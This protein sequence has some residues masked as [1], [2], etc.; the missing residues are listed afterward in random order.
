MGHSTVQGAQNLSDNWDK[1]TPQQRAKAL[2]ETGVGAALTALT[3]SHA[4]GE[5]E[6]TN[7]AAKLAEPGKKAD[8]AQD[9]VELPVTSA[10]KS[11]GVSATVSA[12]Q[13]PESTFSAPD[14]G[15]LPGPGAK[16]AGTDEVGLSPLQQLR[17]WLPN[18]RSPRQTVVDRM[19]SA[20][21]AVQQRVGYVYDNLQRKAFNAESALMGLW[22]AYRQPPEWTGLDDAIGKWQ[23]ARQY[24][25]HELNQFAETLKASIPDQSRREALTNYLQAGGDENV[26]R[27]RAAASKAQFRRGYRTALTLSPNERVLANNLRNYLDGMLDEAKRGGLLEQGVQDY[28]SQIWQKSPEQAARLQALNAASDLSTNPFFTK[29]RIFKDYFE[30]ESKGFQPVSKDVGFLLSAYEKSFAKAIADKG[31][32]RQLLNTKASDGRPLVQV[33]GVGRTLT[34]GELS[35]ETKAHVI[36]PHAK[37]ENAADYIAIDAPAMRKWKWVAKDDSGNPIYLEGDV[38]AH[39]EVARKLKNVLTPSAI[40]T[41]KVGRAALKLSGEFKNTLLSMSAFH[42]VQ[43]GVHGVEHLVNPTRLPKLALETPTQRALIEHGL[44]IASFDAREAFSEGLHSSGLVNKVP[45]IGKHLARYQDYLFKDYLPRLKMAMASHA[46]ERNTKRYANKLSRD[47][48]LRLTAE[49]ANAAFGHL[50]YAQLG[51]NKTFQDVLRLTLLAP[52]FLEAR[53]R[54]VGQA[55]KPFGREQSRALATGAAVMYVGARVLNQVLNG[56]SYANDPTMAFSVRIRNRVY[57]LRTVQG[58]ILHL[59]EKPREFVE[60]RLNPIATRPLLEAITGRDTF[61]R[62][63]NAKDQLKDFA[64]NIVPIPLQ[65]F[66]KPSDFDVKESV[67]KSLGL[68]ATRYRSPAA[69]TAHELMLKGA[70]FGES[71]RTPAEQKLMASHRAAIDADKFDAGKVRDDFKAGK[72]TEKDARALISESK[73]PQLGRDF[74]RLSLEKALE[75]W[76]VADDEERK[77]LRPILEAKARRQLE[78]RVPSERAALKSKVQAAL[79]EKHAPLKPLPLMLKKILSST[80]GG[81][82]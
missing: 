23:A 31:F 75:V 52:D 36:L 11:P 48:I 10:V 61:G 28:V 42:Q 5:I 3:A 78:N 20:Q 59:I 38:L 24:N 1:M 50:N 55:L 45:G 62:Q 39:P 79:S 51:R 53:G 30:G 43:L 33:S 40:Q 27:E 65:S 74:K 26:L 57:S 8:V 17:E 80:A 69:Q 19:R 41:S 9:S 49:Q 82:R 6:P 47:Q 29:E 7:S 14:P 71:S 76:K 68:T 81:K 56:D 46:L 58:D 60:H 77:Q 32:I 64:T 37:G 4:F 18:V 63:R 22:D 25:A 66:T 54:F 13:A 2:T 12:E 73:T 16:T 44:M 34:A 70:T 21:A 35:A 15:F 67:A 72:L